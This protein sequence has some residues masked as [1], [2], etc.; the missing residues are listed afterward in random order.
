MTAPRDIDLLREAM[1]L[2]PEKWWTLAEI[3]EYLEKTH[4]HRFERIPSDL[5]KL[6][7]RA[8]GRYRL[9]QKQ[10]QYPKVHCYRLLHPEAKRGEQINLL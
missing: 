2:Y 1:L 7:T 3:R 4:Q 9:E 5:R 6:T 8:H 10:R